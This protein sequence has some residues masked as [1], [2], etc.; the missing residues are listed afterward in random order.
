MK[1]TII[2]GHPYPKSFNY[3]ILEKVKNKTNATIINLVEDNFN[4]AMLSDDLA[5]FSRGQ[6]ADPLVEKYQDILKMTE[7]LI[8]ITPI[9]W[10]GLPA[11]YKGFL[12]KVMLKGFAYTE[13]KGRL[14]GELTNIKETLIITTSEAPKWYIKY[15]AGN[16]MR[17]LSKRVF[18]DIGLKKVRWIHQGNITKTTQD[19]RIKFL[20]YVETKLV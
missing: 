19:K 16:P 8:I 5:G 6:Y 18:K 7:K 10:Y 15:F 12:D 2:I 9:W 14:I 20:D 17:V 13:E 11:L 4:P 1:T 3:A